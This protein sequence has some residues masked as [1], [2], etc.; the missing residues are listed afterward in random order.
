MAYYH[1]D[2]LQIFFASWDIPLIV[3]PV[4][5][6]FFT[7]SYFNSCKSVSIQTVFK[8]SKNSLIGSGQSSLSIYI[9]KDESTFLYVCVCAVRLKRGIRTEKAT[10]LEKYAK[11]M[12]NRE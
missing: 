12:R 7:F 1:Y 8:T 6:G 9:Y 10:N 11:K 5:L 2:F 3:V 4:I